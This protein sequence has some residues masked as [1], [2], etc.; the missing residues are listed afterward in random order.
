MGVQSYDGGGQHGHLGII[1]PTVEYTIQVPGEE[2]L[3]L[4]NPCP[5][6]DIPDGVDTVKANIMIQEHGELLWAYR[7]ANNVDKACV[8][9]LLDAFDFKFMSTRADPII[10]YANETAIS[11]ITHL[12]E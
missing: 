1:M 4:D 3:R 7:L 8:K 10:R 5:T 9:L 2:L 6:A 11:L 12:K